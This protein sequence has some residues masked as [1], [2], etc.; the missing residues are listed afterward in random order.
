MASFIC[1]KCT[2][3]ETL[4]HEDNRWYALHFI[5]KLVRGF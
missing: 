5:Y 3:N 1:I 2:K 4:Y